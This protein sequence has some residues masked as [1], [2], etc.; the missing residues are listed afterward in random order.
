MDEQLQHGGQEKA[1]AADQDDG[2]GPEKAVEHAAQNRADEIGQH[3]HLAD[4]RVCLHQVPLRLEQGDA[5]VDGGGVAGLDDREQKQRDRD[6]GHGVFLREQQAEAQRQGG[7]GE[8]QGNHDVPAVHP[9]REDSAEGGEE[10]GGDHGNG[11]HGAEDRR[12]PGG[13]QDVQGQGEAEDRV[14]EQGD[15]LPDGNQGEIAVEKLL[16]HE[17]PPLIHLVGM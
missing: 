7:R 13:V 14:S 17:G 16:G 8:V 2:H 9:V 1:H 6:E 15:E 11:R 10:D 4:H 12:G 3:G 5:G